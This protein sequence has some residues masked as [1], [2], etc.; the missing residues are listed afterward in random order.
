[1]YSGVYLLNSSFEI[2][3]LIDTERAMG[4]V[5]T[6]RAWILM[7]V[8]GKVIRSPQQ[9]WPWPTHIVLKNWVTVPFF[10]PKIHDVFASRMGVLRRDGFTCGY[11]GATATTWDHIQPQSKGGEDTWVNTIAACQPCNARKGNKTPEQ[12][13]MKLLWDPKNPAKKHNHD[14]EQAR[15]WKLIEEGNLE[16]GD[17]DNDDALGGE[18]DRD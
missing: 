18:L 3:R 2:L 9:T 12:A 7:S 10:A 4:L 6:D 15:I 17:L 11:C 5:A 14:K 13:N 16:P 8:P 1:M